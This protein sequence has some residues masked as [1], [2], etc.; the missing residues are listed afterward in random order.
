[1]FTPISPADHSFLR[2][3]PRRLSIT[4]DKLSKSLL[5]NTEG[6]IECNTSGSIHISIAPNAVAQEY[7]TNEAALRSKGI[8]ICRDAEGI[9]IL[10]DPF[11][12]IPL[13]YTENIT[14][15]TA[16]S[17]PQE[18][19]D[20][21][22][23]PYDIVG[24][25]ETLLLNSPLWNRTPFKGIKFLPA[26]C[27]LRLGKEVK[28]Q[29]Y[30]NFEFEPTC[31]NFNQRSF[32]CDFDDLLNLKFSNIH[33]DTICMGLS[34][35]NDSRLAAYY[36]AKNK[37]RF[38][39]IELITYAAHPNSNEFRY[40]CEVADTLNLKSPHLHL[41]RD[42]HYQDGLT[43][44]PQWSAGQINNQH[45]HFSSYLKEVDHATDGKTHL[46]NYYTDAV[47]GF[48]CGKQEPLS[49]IFTA[50]AYKTILSARHISESIRAEMLD[51]CC[52]ALSPMQGAENYFSSLNEFKYVAERNPRFHLSLAFIQSQ[53]MP[54]ALPFADIDV[55]KMAMQV[56]VNLRAHKGI[57]DK[58]LNHL[59]PRLT[60][61]GSSANTEYFYGSKSRLCNGTLAER[62]EFKKFRFL[63]MTTQLLSKLS[64]GMIR[65][66]NPYQTEDQ[67]SV[68]RK[69]FSH[70]TSLV[71]ANDALRECLGRSVIEQIFRE[72]LYLRNLAERFHLIS[73]HHLSMGRAK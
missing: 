69:S 10:N 24:V 50:S 44:L 17:D 38:S 9:R 25:W 54:T 46:S 19:I 47:F 61:I 35:G 51:D 18:L 41:L 72:D 20:Y 34:G 12:T 40:A 2:H 3:M 42:D 64:G 68:Y 39:E 5:I 1:M 37:H 71:V 31:S 29:R 15:F 13:Y 57:L 56:P 62:M 43:Y 22:M 23:H 36:L 16:S 49:G 45:C 28:L 59:N 32:F 8:I 58:L 4:Y 53:F 30:W 63:N 60:K 7:N 11:C 21:R 70:L 65:I 55:I 52:L 67:I 48:E 33:A 6:L 27:E 14:H 73:F 66:G 26:A